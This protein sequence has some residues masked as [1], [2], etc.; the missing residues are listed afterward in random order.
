MNKLKLHHRSY[1]KINKYSTKFSLKA[2]DTREIT[3]C[4]HGFPIS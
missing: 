1:S 2:M 4:V 3:L